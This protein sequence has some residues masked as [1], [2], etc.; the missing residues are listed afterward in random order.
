MF[1]YVYSFKCIIFFLLVMR[2]E[3]SQGASPDPVRRSPA[4]VWSPGRLRF[5]CR[6]RDFFSW[7]L[8]TSLTVALACQPYPYV[9][10]NKTSSEI[11]WQKKKTR[12][13][14]DGSELL[15]LIV[16]Q[17]TTLHHP[18]PDRNIKVI[19]TQGSTCLWRPAQVLLSHSDSNTCCVVSHFCWS[20]PP[21]RVRTMA[22]TVLRRQST[23][24]SSV[25]VASEFVL[26]VWGALGSVFRW[27]LVR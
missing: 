26:L 22:L 4:L 5:R 15:A 19:L 16:P 13:S 24:A 20:L 21:F 27:F 25:C 14:T 9:I 10:S 11:F 1:L 6:S 12:N 3:T 8:V 2:W 23:A 18:R 7:H 17:D